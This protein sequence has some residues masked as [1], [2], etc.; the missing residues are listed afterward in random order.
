[1]L[2]TSLDGIGSS[3]ILADLCNLKQTSSES[4]LPCGIQECSDIAD[5]DTVRMVR[6]GVSKVTALVIKSNFTLYILK[7]QSVVSSEE[8]SF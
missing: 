4:Y 6:I 2:F 7:Y 1:M 5:I 8:L 3:V